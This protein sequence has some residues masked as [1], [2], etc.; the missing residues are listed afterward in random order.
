MKKKQK[1]IVIMIV[2][3]II[4]S[5]QRPLLFLIIIKYNNGLSA[6]QIRKS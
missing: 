2:T 6:N 3:D 5:Y 4:D 1:V